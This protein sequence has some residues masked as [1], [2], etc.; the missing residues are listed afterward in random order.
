M[1]EY[2]L[3]EFCEPR[4]VIID[5]AASGYETGEVIELEAG[6]HTI[7]LNKP[8]NFLPP[9]QDANSAGTSPIEHKVIYFDRV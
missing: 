3:V 5:G 9:E 8:K 1:Y 4:E 7:T 6:I 2:I